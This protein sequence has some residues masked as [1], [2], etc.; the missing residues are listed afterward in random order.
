MKTS[1]EKFMASSAVNQVE[2]GEHKIELALIDDV[3]NKRD[4]AASNIV[5]L[6]GKM[7]SDAME[8][9]KW[10]TQLVESMDDMT[11]L[12]QQAKDLGADSTVKQLESL[13]SSTNSLTK[14]WY[15][16]IK[17]INTAISNI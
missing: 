2:L 15:N 9:D 4:I 16:S 3:K 7:K 8:F 13:K 12:I 5:R 14:E 6:K 11:K 17:A 1:F 10:I